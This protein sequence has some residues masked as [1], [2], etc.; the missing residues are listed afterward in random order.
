MFATDKGAEMYFVFSNGT[1]NPLLCLASTCRQKFHDKRT[2]PLRVAFG[3][4][5]LLSRSEKRKRDKNKNK[6]IFRDACK[7][8]STQET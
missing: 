5:D 4:H 8:V 6:Y 1:T 2:K 3:T 7:F